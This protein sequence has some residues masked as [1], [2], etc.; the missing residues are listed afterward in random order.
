MQNAY[1][2]LSVTAF[3]SPVGG[4]A[5]LRASCHTRR[6]G[7]LRVS[8]QREV[9]SIRGDRA[10]GV[11][12][13]RRETALL[14]QV[15]R[16]VVRHHVEEPATHRGERGRN[17]PLASSRCAATRLSRYVPAGR[18]LPE[19]RVEPVREHRPRSVVARPWRPRPRAGRRRASR[20]RWSTSRRQDRDPDGSA[21]PQP[22]DGSPRGA[23]LA[24]RHPPAFH[25]ADLPVLP[26]PVLR[27]TASGARRAPTPHARPPR[28]PP[29]RRPNRARRPILAGAV[30]PGG[31]GGRAR[32][33]SAGRPS[34]I[35]TA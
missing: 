5:R 31:A 14:A 16:E 35:T 13:E 4:R 26:A 33:P 28:R 34:C 6:Y 9:A 29:G 21:A 3:S 18:H 17:F 15:R 30:N 20:S 32:R 11:A 25:P 10:G 2:R 27:R 7:G 12:R 1:R 24:V 22:S 19:P 23:Q 8:L